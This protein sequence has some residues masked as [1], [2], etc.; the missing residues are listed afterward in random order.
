[1]KTHN[2]R[3]SRSVKNKKNIEILVVEDYEA[4][5]ELISDILSERGYHVETACNGVDGLKM[6]MKK[7]YDLVLIDLIMPDI[8]GWELAEKIKHLSKKTPIALMTG[9]PVKLTSEELHRKG[10]DLFISK[11]FR[12]EQLQQLVSDGIKFKKQRNEK[13]HTIHT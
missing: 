5:R 7:Y 8:S 12:D 1:M 6:F 3:K 4:I 2:L 11:P 10:F 9:W 13:R